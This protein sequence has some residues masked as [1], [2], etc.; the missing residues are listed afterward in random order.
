MI[1]DIRRRRWA[2]AALAAVLALAAAGCGNTTEQY[3]RDVLHALDQG[4]LTGTRG[5]METIGRA[6][7]AYAVDR[8]GY[9]AGG[10][11]REMLAALSPAFLPMPQVADAW[12][13]ELGYQSDTRSYTLTS[14]GADGRI[15]SDDDVVMVEGRF[16]QLPR[17]AGQ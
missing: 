13:N 4:K 2:T 15:G 10:S 6:L 12:G 14:P 17:P 16:T 3:S 11:A 8:G 7:S 9:P 1:D 5:T